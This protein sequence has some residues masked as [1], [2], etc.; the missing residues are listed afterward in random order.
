[1]KEA[2][3]IKPKRDFNKSSKGIPEIAKKENYSIFFKHDGCTMTLFC[4]LSMVNANI[5]KSALERM[6]NDWCGHFI[7]TKG[8]ARQK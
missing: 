7:V 4:G 6:Y 5:R 2:I 1:M 8:K 3:K